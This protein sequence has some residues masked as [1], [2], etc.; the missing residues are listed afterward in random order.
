MFGWQN[1]WMLEMTADLRRRKLLAEAEND[2]V[3]V[4]NG[5]ELVELRVPPFNQRKMRSQVLGAILTKLYGEPGQTVSITYLDEANQR[6]EAALTMEK[7]ARH[8]FVAEGLPPMYV[9]S[10][11]GV[12]RV[13]LPT[14]APTGSCPRSWMEC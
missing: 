6:Y 3:S 1:F 9:D 7:R 13:A 4:E 2:G 8:P 5:E 12:W 11:P 14:S 10:K